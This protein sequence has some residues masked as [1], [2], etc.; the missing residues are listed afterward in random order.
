MPVT[1]HPVTASR[2]DDHMVAKQETR[3]RERSAH[4]GP[5]RDRSGPRVRDRGGPPSRVVTCDARGRPDIAERV[6][7]AKSFRE[8]L[9]F[10]PNRTV[11]IG[12]A[13]RFFERVAAIALEGGDQRA[14]QVFATLE[15][16]MGR[17][18][19]TL[20][21]AFVRGGEVVEVPFFL[22][23][24]LSGGPIVGLRSLAIET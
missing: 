8:A 9:G 16:V 24:R 3:L 5:D 19:G 17:A 23:G 12:P 14:Q 15:L 6:R 7:R 2:F 21:Q 20:R 13:S 10:E 18:L 11:D 22:F 1:L 4:A